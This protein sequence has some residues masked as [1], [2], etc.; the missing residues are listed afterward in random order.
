MWS[1]LSVVDTQPQHYQ[2]AVWF[3]VVIFKGTINI[4]A[5][6]NRQETT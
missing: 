5:K 4:I 6:A 1:V 3:G 2:Y